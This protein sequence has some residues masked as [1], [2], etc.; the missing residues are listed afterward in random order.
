M[1]AISGR[2]LL[3]PRGICTVG[4]NSP[5]FSAACVGSCVIG[6]NDL[7]TFSGYA[8]A[9]VAGDLA[10]GGALLEEALALNP[11]LAIAW[12]NSGFVKLWSGEI[13]TAIECIMRAV[14]LSPLDPMLHVMESAIAHAHYQADRFEQAASW[15]EKALRRQPTW[16]PAARVAA[17]SYAQARRS[18]QVEQAMARLRVMQPEL[19]VSNLRDVTGPYR[20]EALRKFEQGLRLAGVPE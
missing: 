20:P 11:N 15:A 14:R 16:T 1:V 7:V 4:K 13:E 10:A 6:D 5:R 19:R 3:W 9:F 17:A 8:L 12:S 18:D 2:A